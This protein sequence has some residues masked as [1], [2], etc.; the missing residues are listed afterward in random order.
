MQ[1][2]ALETAR[3]V[4]A[5]LAGQADSAYGRVDWV[6]ASFLLA[7]LNT[8]VIGALE[9]DIGS[10]L[11]FAT[12]DLN[13]SLREGTPMPPPSFNPYGVVSARFNINN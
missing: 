7:H 10:G 2:Y 1:H 8:P 9:P 6:T 12:D 3:S 4:R 5:L 11:T 13:V